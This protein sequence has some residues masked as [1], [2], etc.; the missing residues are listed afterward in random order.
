MSNIIL[1]S[2]TL[3]QVQDAAKADSSD[4]TIYYRGTVELPP[5]EAYDFEIVNPGNEPT[6]PIY[7]IPADKLWPTWAAQVRLDFLKAKLE[8]EKEPSIPGP[9]FSHLVE[10]EIIGVTDSEPQSE[11]Q[12]RKLVRE[13]GAFIGDKDIWGTIRSF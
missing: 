9:C 3:R 10:T 8:E 5:G 1:K 7:A 13:N 6:V 4:Y 2:L 11:A 12:I